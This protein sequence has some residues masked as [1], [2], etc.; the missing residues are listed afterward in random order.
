MLFM[1]PETEHRSLEDIE[2]HYSDSKKSLFDIDI[3]INAD[4][5]EPD[6]NDTKNE[7]KF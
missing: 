3:R 1:L 5:N 4:A 2:F 6:S 7:T